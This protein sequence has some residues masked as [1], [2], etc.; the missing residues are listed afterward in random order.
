MHPILQ[1]AQLKIDRAHEKFNALKEAV[2]PFRTGEAYHHWRE[3]YAPFDGMP[4]HAVVRFW[5]IPKQKIPV[6]LGV[7]IGEILHDLRSA[8]DHI[9]YELSRAHCEAIQAA[10]DPDSTQFPIF[11]ADKGDPTSVNKMLRSGFSD[12]VKGQ[13]GPR[14]LLQVDPKVRTHIQSLQPFATGEGMNSPLWQLQELN[15]WDKHR[16]IY[17]TQVI[18]HGASVEVTAGDGIVGPIVGTNGPLQNQALIGGVILAPRDGL[19]FDNWANQ[20]DVKLEFTTYVAFENPT[21]C[22]GIPVDLVIERI[23]KRVGDILK[24]IDKAFF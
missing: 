18:K 23:G 15:N 1:G 14:G 8:L 24:G 17:T 7:G 20:V 22:A 11:L 21:P 19:S 3:P 9:A 6:F 5:L 12:K 13:Q 16:T 2:K 4:G 10:F